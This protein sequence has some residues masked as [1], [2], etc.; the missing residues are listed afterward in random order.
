METLMFGGWYANAA[1]AGLLRLRCGLSR[2]VSLQLH[3]A[4][5]GR[6]Q[7]ALRLDHSL[8]PIDQTQRP[9]VNGR[10]YSPFPLILETSVLRPDSLGYVNARASAL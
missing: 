5:M 1:S 2:L 8:P 7:I 10:P 3:V 9:T 6:W 4:D